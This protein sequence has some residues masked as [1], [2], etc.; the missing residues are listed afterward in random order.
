MDQ[1]LVEFQNKNKKSIEPK[2]HI[3]NWSVHKSDDANLQNDMNTV[4]A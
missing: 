2:I 1:D 4:P 3:K